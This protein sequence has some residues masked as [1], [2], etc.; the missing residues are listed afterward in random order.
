MQHRPLAYRVVLILIVGLAFAGCSSTS[1]AATT[2]DTPKRSSEMQVLQRFV[3]TWDQRMVNTTAAEE[4]TSVEIRRWSTEGTFVL[5]ES[6]QHSAG[7]PE[8]LMLIT[9]DSDA[10]VYPA[11]YMFGPARGR[12]T[13]TWD[14]QTRTMT[15]NGTDM[16]GNKIAGEHR[17]VDRDQAEWSLVFTAP[18]G[19]VVTALSGKQTRRKK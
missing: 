13:G 17:F 1:G 15:W 2:D 6:T 14:E 8:S 4:S 3:G 16:S 7:G 12:L 19:E 18:G 9:Y 10:H 5:M 11:C